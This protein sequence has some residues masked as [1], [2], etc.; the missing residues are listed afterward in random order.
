MGAH[1]VKNA[2][3]AMAVAAEVGV[4]EDRFRQGLCEFAGVKRRLEVVGTAAGVTVF[5]DFA[6]H[7]TAVRETIRAV[8]ERFGSRRLLAVFEPR[9]NSSRR[10]VFQQAYAGAFDLA[11]MIIIPEP[12][13]MEKVPPEERFSSSELVDDLIGNGR[14]AFYSPNTDALLE[15]LLHLCRPGDVVLFMSNGAF[16]NLPARLVTK[17]EGMR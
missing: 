12:P 15:E 8:R 6:H 4:G 3:A 5:D 10:K 11:D 17:L 1:N 2:L 14:Q 16:D 13:L 7:P 9:S